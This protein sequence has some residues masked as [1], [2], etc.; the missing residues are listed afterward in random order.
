MR[1]MRC[2]SRPCFRRR[3]R[4]DVQAL[5]HQFGGAR[6]RSFG[7]SC[8]R[9]SCSGYLADALRRPDSSTPSCGCAPF[10]NSVCRARRASSSKDTVMPIRW[11]PTTR[12]RIAPRTGADTEGGETRR[13]RRRRL[14]TRRSN[15]LFSGLGGQAFGRVTPLCPWYFPPR[16]L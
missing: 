14:T 6:F 5:L 12:R 11:C 1:A 15:S 4:A 13:R 2:A 7:I 9:E 16:S 3:T 8:V 10:Q